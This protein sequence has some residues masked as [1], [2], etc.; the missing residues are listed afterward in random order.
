VLYCSVNRAT[1]AGLA[2]LVTLPL[3][4]PPEFGKLRFLLVRQDLVAMSDAKAAT[5]DEATAPTDVWRRARLWGVFAKGC[6]L[7]LLLGAG[8]IAG[9]KTPEI[10]D[11]AQVSSNARASWG[12]SFSRICRPR[13]VGAGS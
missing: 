6:V 9:A 10:A 11:L 13:S 4:L 1:E 3:S 8:W 5:Q 7:A 12:W 2:R